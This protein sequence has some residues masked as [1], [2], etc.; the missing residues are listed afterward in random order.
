MKE[1]LRKIGSV[2]TREEKRK[3]GWLTLVDIIISVADI[4]F[5][6]LLLFIIHLYT[7]PVRANSL[8]LPLIR[9]NELSPLLLIVGFFLLFSAKN[10]AGFLNYRAQC[11]YLFQVATR[12]SRNKLAEYLS[13]S[14]TGYVEV[15]SSVNVR[16]ISHDPS[17]FSQHVLGGI[18]QIITQT[19]L[20]LLSIIGIVLFNARLFLLLF[21]ILLPPVVAI[22]YH[23][24]R[25]RNA[26][27]GQAK[28]T[29][30][31]SLQHLQEA[32]TGYVE[33]NIY[34][35]NSV[36]L[37]RYITVQERF[38]Q[39][40]SDQLIVQG[41]PNRMIEVFHRAARHR[42]PDADEQG[43]RRR[44]YRRHYDRGFYRCRL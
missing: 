44:G 22:F 34:D 24:R 5:L 39:Y 15:D 29:S 12:I 16:E 26:V 28:T 18:Q 13:G 43:G 27:R 17:E 35:K 11:R 9:L 1:L 8:S 6:A 21:A 31:K 38:N 4:A 7:G 33:S 36:F 19:V 2:L 37:Q 25:K 32:L 40:I 3:L 10:L 14:Y 42:Y 23:I 20:I 30:E 41:I